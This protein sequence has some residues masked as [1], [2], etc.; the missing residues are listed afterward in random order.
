MQ[1]LQRQAILTVSLHDPALLAGFIDRHLGGAFGTVSVMH[2]LFAQL[3]VTHL[4]A[5]VRDSLSNIRLLNL[6]PRRRRRGWLIG[7]GEP[8]SVG[9]ELKQ[10]RRLRGG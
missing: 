10:S 8:E 4:L 3:V 9:I 2:D 1:K 6:A 7:R 5:H